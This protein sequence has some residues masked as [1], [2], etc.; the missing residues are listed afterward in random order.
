MNNKRTINTCIQYFKENMV[1]RHNI[2]STYDNVNDIDR[3]V[4]SGL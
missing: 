3:S 1:T 4:V 2:S